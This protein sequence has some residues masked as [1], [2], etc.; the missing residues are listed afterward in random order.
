MPGQPEEGGRG[1]EPEVAELQGHEGQE[2][3]L[4]GP[5][6]HVVPQHTHHQLKVTKSLKGE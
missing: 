5:L 3:Q 2:V 4:E 6:R 1:P